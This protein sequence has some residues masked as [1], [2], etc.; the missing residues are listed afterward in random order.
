MTSADL[1]GR[2]AGLTSWRADWRGLRAVVLGLGV[3][4]FSSADTLAELGADVLV[5]AD[6][7]H[8]ERARLLDVIGARLHVGDLTAVPDAVSAFDPE[9]VVVSS[10]RYHPDH[11]LLAWAESA[12]IAVWSD[13]ELAWRVRD[14]VEPA[15]EWICIT[16]TNGKTTTVELAATFLA[17]AGMRAAPCGNIGIPVLDA[18]R[19]PQGFDVLVV[20]L[21]SYQLHWINRSAGGEIF[22]FSSACLNLAEDHLDFHGSLRAYASAKAK[23]YDN[24]KVACVYNRADAA[25]LRM[26]EEADVMEGARAIGFG[27]DTPGPSDFGIVDGILCDRAFLDDRATTALE[28]TTLDDLRA[29]GLGAPHVVAN[30]LAASALARSFGVPTDVIRNALQTFRLDRHRIE[31]VAEH[32]GVTW[33]DDS[34]ATN[35]HAADASLRAFERIVWVLGGQLKGVELDDLVQRHAARLAGAVVIGLD[36]EPV[37]AAFRRHAPELRVLPVGARETEHVMPEAVRLAAR[38]ARGGDTV[39]LAPAAA[40]LDQFTDFADRGDRFARAVHDLLADDTASS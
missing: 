12:G 4:A 33:I 40:S 30:I 6:A 7:L 14:K 8:E 5:V 34:K 37:L 26:V 22:P 39:L 21:S 24:T 18:I 2:L 28:L 38:L 13:V 25:T 17:A 32:G 19:N 36:Q 10:G 20:E 23:V 29:A 27:L 35:P 11:A 16:G 15:A 3:A 31:V 1:P 9:V